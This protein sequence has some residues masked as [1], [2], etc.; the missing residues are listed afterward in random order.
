MFVESDQASVPRTH[1]HLAPVESDATIDHIPANEQSVVPRHLR[2]VGPANIFRLRIDGVD[3][4]P[5]ARGMD[6]PILYERCSFQAQ[7]SGRVSGCSVLPLK[8]CGRGEIGR[9]I[10]L[11]RKLEC[12]LGNRRCRTAQIR[13]TL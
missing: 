4:V 6:D 12:S 3:H 9:R 13:G 10:G 1:I 7:K 5:S 2:I 8:S 11:K